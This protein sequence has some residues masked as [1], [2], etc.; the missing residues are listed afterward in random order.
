MQMS[1]EELAAALMC[2]R[3]FDDKFELTCENGKKMDCNKCVK[4][5]LESEDTKP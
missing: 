3:E 4:K 2:P 5:Y 1:I